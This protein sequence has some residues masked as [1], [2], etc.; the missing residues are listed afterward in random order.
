MSN[1]KKKASSKAGKPPKLQPPKRLSKLKAAPWNP[2]TIDPDAAR[3]LLKSLDEFGDISGIVVHKDGY[4]IAGHQRVEAIRTKYGTD[5]PIVGGA[6]TAPDGTRYPVRVVDWPEDK[7]KAANLAANNP[8]I[9]GKFTSEGAAMVDLVALSRP[10][11]A[12]EL[13]LQ[14]MVYELPEDGAEGPDGTG[15]PVIDRI[16]PPAMELQP[17]EHYDYLV[18]LASNLNDWAWLCDRLGIKRVD[19]SPVPAKKK[20]GLGRA[21]PAARLI[22]ALDGSGE[23]HG[24]D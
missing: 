7:S 1:R 6:I 22:A 3:G 15:E 21:I 16:G 14:E 17:F 12:D 5:L 23:S 18:V 11:L 8:L 4:L 20:I 9:G 10:D 2:R 13:R 24:S 19:A